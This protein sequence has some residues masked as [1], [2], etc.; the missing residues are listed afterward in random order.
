MWLCVRSGLMIVRSMRMMIVKRQ[1]R[2]V[3]QGFVQLRV[4]AAMGCLHLLGSVP[5]LLKKGVRAGEIRRRLI[6]R[7]HGEYTTGCHTLSNNEV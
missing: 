1:G 7:E 5:D 3:V 4:Q 6:R 2:L